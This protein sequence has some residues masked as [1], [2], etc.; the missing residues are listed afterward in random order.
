MDLIFN[1]NKNSIYNNENTIQDVIKEWEQSYLSEFTNDSE[2]EAIVNGLYNMYNQEWNTGKKRGRDFLEE[3]EI[4]YELIKCIEDVYKCYKDEYEYQIGK[5]DLLEQK[6]D[7]IF[8]RNARKEMM[9]AIE[10]HELNINL[11]VH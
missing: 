5:N 4:D 7:F 3:N 8:L 2:E 9:N 10:Y 1:W 6:L 11:W